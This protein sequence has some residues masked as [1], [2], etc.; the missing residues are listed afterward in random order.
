MI[1]CTASV[2]HLNVVGVVVVVMVSDA[3]LCIGVTQ[4][5]GF[6]KGLLCL[7]TFRLH[8]TGKSHCS[9]GIMCGLNVDYSMF[10]GF[11]L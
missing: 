3:G 11:F 4:T 1:L 2:L 10:W 9:C 6:S 7:V 8:I 5:R